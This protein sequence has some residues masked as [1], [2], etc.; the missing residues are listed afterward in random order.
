MKQMVMTE[1]EMMEDSLSSQKHI[2]AGYNTCAGE[3][4]SAQLR[5]AVLNILADEQELGSQIFDAMQARGWYQIKEAEQSDVSK[6]KQK[7]IDSADSST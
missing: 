2:A 5:T 4:N 3:C 1:R 7:F 6:T